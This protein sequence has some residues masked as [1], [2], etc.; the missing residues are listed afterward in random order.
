MQWP[1]KCPAC[2]KS[3]DGEAYLLQR[4]APD[5]DSDMPDRIEDSI[6]ECSECHALFKLKWKLES[7]E[8]LVAISNNNESVSKIEV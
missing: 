6:C 4:A 2:N 8:Q 1:D 7:F 3:F 5:W